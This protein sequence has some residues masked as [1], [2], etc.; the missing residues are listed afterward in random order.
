MLK[1]TSVEEL[2]TLFLDCDQK[3]CTDTRKVLENSV[4]FA[5]KGPHFNANELAQ[6]A[7]SLG[8]R[9][10]IVDEEKYVTGDRIFLVQDVLESL[11]MLAR[12]HRR[13]FG[14]PVLAITGSNGKTTNKELINAVLSGKFKTLATSGNLN[15]HIGVPLTLLGLRKEHQFA[16]IEM[17]ANHQGEISALCNIAEP[18]FGLITNIGQAHLEGFGGLEG[19]KKGKAELYGFIKIKDGKV[20]VNG[21][22]DVLCALSSGNSKIT[23]G[24]KKLYD[25]I[26]KDFTSGNHVR[27]KFTTRYGE[28]NWDKLPVISTNIIGRYNF[29]N[30]LA[31]VCVG[32]YFDVEAGSI[33]QAIESYTPAM[34]RSQLFETGNNTIILDAYNANPDSMKAAI[35]N[36]A[37]FSA[38][39]KMLLLGDMF[40]LGAFSE[41][42]HQKIITILQQHGFENVILVGSEFYKTSSDNYRKFIT[43]DACR[44]FLGKEK[45]KGY[46]V[47]IKGSR[48]MRMESLTEV[49]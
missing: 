6:E 15:N 3:I 34:N 16:I 31:A 24:S 17:G 46:T 18:D 28:K 40:E 29:I 47:L 43:T 13:Q 2:Y 44:E 37:G 9:Y 30:C 21:D 32:V 22:D 4:F 7:L 10:A 19:V 14:I 8:C 45:L 20:F 12:H 5:L 1:M 41:L 39:K 49:L 48:G 26:G 33:G 23:Y 36:F 27:F 35:E 42:Q 25:V 38:G 11:Q